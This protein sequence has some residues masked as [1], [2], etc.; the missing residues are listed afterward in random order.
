MNRLVPVLLLACV[1]LAGC[2]PGAPISITG[3]VPVINSFNASPSSISAGESSELSWTV[4]GA[5]SVSIDQG[6]GSVALTG[7]RAAAPTVTT[8]YTLTASSS[9]GSITA[10]TQVIVSGATSPPT[11]TGLPVISSFMASPSIISLGSS[12]TLSWNVSNATSVSINQG[13]G[14]VGYSGSTIVSPSTTVTYTLTA[15]NANGS[16]TATAL[17]QV[18]GEPSPP[19]LPVI[20]Y[21][22]ASPPII[23]VG[24]SSLLR[25]SA[26]NAT[27]VTIDNGIGPVASHGTMIVSPSYSTNYTL[28]AANA[29]G[30]TTRTL[31][32]LVGGAPPPSSLPSLMSPPTPARLLGQVRAPISSTSPQPLPSMDPAQ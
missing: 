32:V 4:T 20:D 30:Y 29:Y 16:L 21:F 23:S 3:Q 13:V 17:V 2:Y 26:S 18:S 14:P 9:A 1:F 22:T 8:T 12:T 6:I 25:W 19:S 24:G 27:S 7:S 15:S 28:T 11:T 10:T 31:S 5:T